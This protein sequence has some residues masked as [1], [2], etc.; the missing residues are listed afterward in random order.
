MQPDKKYRILR[1]YSCIIYKNRKRFLPVAWNTNTC[2][3]KALQTRNII[4]KCKFSSPDFLI[5]SEQWRSHNGS[6]MSTLLLYRIHYTFWSDSAPEG[7]LFHIYSFIEVTWSWILAY[8]L[9]NC[10]LC[11]DN[12][13]DK[14]LINYRHKLS[15]SES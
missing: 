14:H 2:K 12:P 11:I 4:I 9:L 8:I 15:W 13:L 10:S 5:Q 1:M 7:H 3:I 6:N